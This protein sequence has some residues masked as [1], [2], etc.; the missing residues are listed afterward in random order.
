VVLL[1][2]Y[3]RVAALQRLGRDTAMVERWSCDLAQGLIT[4]LCRTQ[5]RALAAIEEALILRELIAAGLTQ[6]E[7][8][9]RCGRDVSWVCRRLQLLSGLPE[10]VLAAVARGHALHLG[11]NASHRAIGARQCRAR[12]TAAAQHAHRSAVHAPSS[13]AASSTIGAPGHL[14]RERLIAHPRLFLQA[15]SAS[16]EGRA[17]QRLRAGL[18]GECAADV[19]S[20][21]VL[22]VRLRKRLATLSRDSLPPG[23][24]ARPRAP[25][26]DAR[27][28]LTRTRRRL[29]NMIHEEICT[30]VRAM[31]AQGHRLREIS[32][33]LKLSRNTVRRILRAR[34]AAQTEYAPCDAQ[35]LV[36]VQSCFQRAGANVVRVRE[37]LREEHELEVGYS[38]LTRWVREAGLRAAPKRSG[39]Y[40][41]EPGEEGQHDTSPHRVLIGEQRVTAQCASLILAYSRRLFAQYYPR[42][43]RFEAKHF[44]LEAARF[45]DGVAQR[46]IIDNT[47]VIVADGTGENA[48]F[49]PEMVAFARTLGFEFRA[50]E[51][52]HADRKG[53][54]ERPYSWIERN[55]LPGR[56]FSDFDDLNRQL[57]AWCREVANHKP[58]RVLGMSPEAAYVIEKPYLR[59]LPALLPPVYEVFERVV[60][61]YGYVSVEANRYSAPEKFVGKTLTVY[62]YPAEIQLLHR[63]TLL[64]THPRLINQRDARHTIANHHTIPQRAPRAPALE[65]QLLRGEA[66]VLEHYAAALKQHS[67]RQSVRQLRRLLEMKRTYPTAPFLA[68]LEQALQFGLFDLGRLENLVLKH[69]AGDFFNLDTHSDDDA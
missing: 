18:E 16:G 15:L 1:D 26:H 63:G 6:N 27:S 20:I 11:C 22:I 34:Q 39:G 59:S 2:G 57:L 55:F 36:W 51:R 43:T 67:P 52:G 3:R 33:A 14:A 62:K 44:L 49:A 40:H 65:E 41:F 61:L 25:A 46:C 31:Q 69:V 9:Q 24:G 4:V 58:K 8:A 29:R 48:L 12:R 53:R 5:A 32:R 35:T 68:A 37:L 66:P 23:A 50:H 60:D 21:E 7:L 17:A 64:A 54:I 28:V 42:F 30:A 10:N 13:T 19:R 56:R 45:M 47:S 38:T